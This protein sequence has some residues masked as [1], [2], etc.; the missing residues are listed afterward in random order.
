MS[1]LGGGKADAGPFSCTRCSL[2]VCFGR[3]LCP[4]RPTKLATQS[5]G[6]STGGRPFAL[7]HF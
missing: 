4:D 1:G 2:T 3:V 6:P 5:P 7:R